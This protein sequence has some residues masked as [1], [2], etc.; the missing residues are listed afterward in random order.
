MRSQPSD[1]GSGFISAVAL[2]CWMERSARVTTAEEEYYRQLM[3]KV[4]ADRIRA[5]ALGARVKAADDIELPVFP[6]WNY[7]PCSSHKEITEGC[8]QCGIIFRKHQRKGIAW[9]Y[10]VRSGLLA[11]KVGTG[12]TAQLNGVTALRR[13][14]GEMHSKAR[15][16][17][18]CKPQ[19]LTQW[20]VETHRMMPLV[21]IMLAEGTPK[22]RIAKYMG[23]WEICLMSFN[24]LLNDWEKLLNFPI[25]HV[26]L[27][28]VD[29][30]RHADTRTAYV[31]KKLSQHAGTVA[32]ATGTPLQKK[33]PELH[34]VLEPI[35]GREVFGSEAAFK[36]AYLNFQPITLWRGGRKIR[37]KK[38]VGYK[39]LG[40]FK[41]LVEPFVLRRDEHDIDDAGMP[42]I[43]PNNV[44]LD[45]Y[46]AQ[47]AAY[48]ELRSGVAKII[49]EHGV[50]VSQA[51]SAAKM[52]NGARI[53]AGMASLGYPDAVE[54]SCK[55]D[56][57]MEKLTEDLADDK[58]I[59]F[60]NYKDTIR[61]IASPR[62]TAAG[63]KHVI[64]WGDEPNKAVRQ[65]RVEQFWDDPACRV[66]IGTTA[67]EQSLNLQVAQHMINVDMILNPSRME[68][69]AGRIKRGGSAFKHVYIH[70]LL[71][72]DT[73]EDKYLPLLEKEQAL[74]DHIWDENS[75]LFES[76]SPL[77]LLQLIVS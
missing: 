64:M 30:L 21:P 42:V 3:P 37:A 33:L 70:N 74:V 57:V 28:D 9:L 5:Y 20:A 60:I 62:L 40:E 34:S 27:D 4:P 71:T 63:I 13:M 55:F 2:E 22:E 24:I 31:F 56:W 43:I 12:K 16:V 17:I 15:T 8:R 75:E 38:L 19:A 23:Q 39:R 50:K 7:A 46:P 48:K 11:D 36:I 73:Q 77:A 44:Y 66:L 35:G 18:I 45:L 51:V 1:H 14:K 26:Q 29:A 53:C 67:I 41:T 72:N 47:R 32:E 68:Q 61:N 58:V 54:S 49:T 59:L 25:A 52:H 69:L 65:Q 76:L 6:D 10:V